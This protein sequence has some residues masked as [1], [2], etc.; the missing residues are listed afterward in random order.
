MGKFHFTLDTKGI[1]TLDNV[2]SVYLRLAGSNGV[3]GWSSQAKSI[4]VS[5]TLVKTRQ[6]NRRQQK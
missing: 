4:K 1:D 3:V 6:K 5:G 2:S